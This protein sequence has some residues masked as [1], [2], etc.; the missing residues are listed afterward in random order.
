MDQ[1]V[2][3]GQYV[4]SYPGLGVT[5]SQVKRVGAMRHYIVMRI[6]NAIP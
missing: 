2:P 3:W 1:Q 6:C 5:G 4:R